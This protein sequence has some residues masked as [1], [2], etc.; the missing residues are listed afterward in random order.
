MLTSPYRH[1]QRLRVRLHKKSYI[2]GALTHIVSIVL[3]AFIMVFVFT[4]YIL[5]PFDVEGTSME[6]TLHNKEKVFILRAN[7]IFAD[8]I[9]ADYV[10]KRG[11]MIVFR[12]RSNNEMFVKRVAA[13][14]NERIVLKNNVITIYND[15]NPQGFEVEFN[16]DP[17][18]PDYPPDEP[19]FDRIVEK[20]EVF[21]LGDN[22]HPGKTADSRDAKHVGN[23][24]LDDIR[25][26]IF[27][28]VLPF[29][30][31]KLF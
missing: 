17:P 5:Q 7:K 16:L 9:G 11:E 10:P 22:R 8:L 28:R 19:I 12:N 31:F 25:G 29:K 21:V 4:S 30:D 1:W 26:P 20:G 15:E 18:L 14:P 2:L 27:I 6:P 24:A 3:F 13:L 23:V